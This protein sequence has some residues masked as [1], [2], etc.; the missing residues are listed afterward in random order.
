[1]QR[2]AWH[3]LTEFIEAF[4]ALESCIPS[5]YP[6]VFYIYTDLTR[7]IYHMVGRTPGTNSDTRIKNSNRT[8]THRNLKPAE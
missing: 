4:S 2:K 7:C 8:C 6:R 1:M 3:W 5:R